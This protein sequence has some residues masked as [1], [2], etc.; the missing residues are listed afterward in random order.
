MSQ[1]DRI[2]LRSLDGHMDVFNSMLSPASSFL[3]PSSSPQSGQ[4]PS[5]PLHQV[6]D[7]MSQP[8][9]VRKGVRRMHMPIKILYNLDS[10]ADATMV[11]QIEQRIP[12]DVLPIKRK[13]NNKDN[14]GNGTPVFAR[15]SLKACLQ[16]IC[17]ASPELLSSTTKD[18]VLYAVDPVEAHRASLRREMTS[19][20]GGSQEA[21]PSRGKILRSSA[22][23]M[24]GKGYMSQALTQEGM[25]VSTVHGRVR[26]EFDDEDEEDEELTPEDE[27]DEEFW[28]SR[29]LEI[30]LKLKVSA[31]L[32]NTL[33]E[34]AIEETKLNNQDSLTFASKAP[35]KRKS[36]T[37][38]EPLK[39]LS[40]NQI[41]EDIPSEATVSKGQLSRKPGPQR[42]LL[43]LL[44]A[45][46][47]HAQQG[48]GST[49]QSKTSE[50]EL[51]AL[52]LA[53]DG[54]KGK[55]N[56]LRKDRIRFSSPPISA[57]TITSVHPS[58]AQS[59]PVLANDVSLPISS[60]AVQG[61]STSRRPKAKPSIASFSDARSPILGGLTPGYEAEYLSGPNPS[62]NAESI[63]LTGSARANVPKIAGRGR[64]GDQIICSPSNDEQCY[65]CGLRG[66]LYWRYLEI[67]DESQ[68]RFYDSSVCFFSGAKHFRSCNAC[69]TYFQRYKGVSRPE[70]VFKEHEAKR[71]EKLKRM[72][73]QN[74]SNTSSEDDHEE[75]NKKRAFKVAK[76]KSSAFSRTLSEACAIDSERISGEGGKEKDGPSTSKGKKQTEEPLDTQKKSRKRRKS[77][78]SEKGESKK[79]QPQERKFVD[80]FEKARL[81]DLVMDQ[82]G[83]WRSKRS[84]LEN[85][86]NRRVGRPP[87]RKTGCGLGRQRNTESA[88]AAAAAIRDEMINMKEGNHS[89]L[90]KTRPGFSARDTKASSSGPM[91]NVDLTN[92]F[93]VNDALQAILSSSSP[94]HPTD[95]DHVSGAPATQHSSFAVPYVPNQMLHHQ[96]MPH[97]TP[98]RSL[99]HQN[100]TP[101]SVSRVRYGAPPHLM[102]SSP[103]TAFQT[104]MDEAD[105][106]WKALFGF[107]NNVTR[108]SPRKKPAGVHG[109]INPYAT[110][111]ASPSR[112]PPQQ[113]SGNTHQSP[114]VH[115]DVL[116]QMTS[117]SPLTRNRV[118]SGQFEWAFNSSDDVGTQKKKVS[119]A[120]TSP[121]S[122]SPTRTRILS[123]KR[124]S[125]FD[126][127]MLEAG[128]IN[129]QNTS[130]RNQVSKQAKLTKE[131]ESHSFDNEPFAGYTA[132]NAQ[133][134]EQ[135]DEDLLEEDGGPG[136]PTLGRSMRLDKKK[137]N[138]ELRFTPTANELCSSTPSDLGNNV[139]LGT[140]AEWQQNATIPELFPATSPEKVWNVVNNNS[141]SEMLW[142][143]PSSWALRMPTPS[144]LKAIKK[145]PD[146]A[147]ATVSEHTESTKATA[148]NL[149]TINN[150]HK[151]G[152]GEEKK[153]TSSSLAPPAQKR[154]PLAAT[155]EDASPSE[156][157]NASPNDGEDDDE[158]DDEGVTGENGEMVI[159]MTDSDNLAAFM[160]MFE[161]PYGL[162]AASGINLSALPQAQKPGGVGETTKE[163]TFN[164]SSAAE[165]NL[166]QIELFKSFDYAKELGFFNQA[167][168]TGITANA[169]PSAPTSVESGPSK[170]TNENGTLT[171]NK[172]VLTSPHKIEIDGNFLRISPRKK[173]AGDHQQSFGQ[174]NA[175]TNSDINFGDWIW[176]D[177]QKT[178]NKQSTV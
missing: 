36:A 122:P 56:A 150:P 50:S 151:E 65:N 120:I 96:Q 38:E 97:S 13:T 101:M 117:S 111:L 67:P 22:A 26:G 147:N 152:L 21:S 85:P 176:S 133:L 45:L 29:V 100:K 118:R 87:G 18:Y 172:N 80:D 35:P 60:N 134:I 115:P 175:G 30:F 20:S 123:A 105:T 177:V 124:K 77:N 113:K 165:S 8:K 59:S 144:P 125:N 142:N 15:V 44:Q 34:K 82:E 7:T 112:S 153:G 1:H 139:D 86:T 3:P 156:A 16:G 74:S 104:V 170:I 78:Q 31:P 40:S 37:A 61:S 4:S 88:K 173:T 25:G 28:E 94:A 47:A 102:M 5:N 163:N 132:I 32:Q 143:S 89:S 90:A 141:P 130:R 53:S 27:E 39:A 17:L 70:F 43:H 110:N 84:I 68:I 178:T 167:G 121:T 14:H 126:E 114:T 46:Q 64:K 148:A 9:R 157:S 55:Y 119:S 75:K 91:P 107:N 62:K 154:K 168:A 138:A 48:S 41:V 12:V 2:S 136:S 92:E 66:E 161:D 158:D 33:I 108:R 83:N 95:G 146:E 19:N 63:D 72:S 131:Q 99:N 174:M 137:K 149:S 109:G 135:D 171:E 129:S 93:A 57:S 155:V 169:G 52:E 159:D 79:G 103:A 58:G 116:M 49:G 42:Q 10:N 76:G 140:Q 54:G 106:D 164:T 162:L 81:R 24:V 160:Q 51:Q 73:S 69:G 127:V 166:A 145:I 71:L 6:A 11:A 23:F 98:G 128:P